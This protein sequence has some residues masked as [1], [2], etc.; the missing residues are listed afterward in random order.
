MR[1]WQA[2]RYHIDWLYIQTPEEQRIFGG[3]ID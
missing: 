1:H 3:A 2:L